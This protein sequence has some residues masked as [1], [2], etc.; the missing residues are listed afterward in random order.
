MLS[1]LLLVGLGGAL[2]AISRFY[3]TGKLNPTRGF[4]IGTLLVNVVGSFL[5]GFLWGWLE[6]SP[7]Y[8]FAGVGFMGALT[9]FS[10]L[11]V[12]LHKL[13]KKKGQ[14][15]IYLVASYLMG[16]LLAYAGYLLV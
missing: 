14:W 15:L 4:P 6:G 12:E 13:R 9:T 11:H 1:Q 2:G 16:F 5:L 7:F 3:I 10:T 8:L